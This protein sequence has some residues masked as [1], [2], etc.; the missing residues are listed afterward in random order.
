M[1]APGGASLAAVWLGRRAYRPV[2]ALQQELAA[3]RRRGE[4]RDVLLLLEHE[5]VV[6]LGRGADRA[7][8]LGGEALL[9]ARGLDLV[10]TDRG[11]DVT[12]HAPGQLVGYPIVALEGP[13][14]DVRRWVRDL[15]GTMG[16]V[17][18]ALG[19]EGG[20]VPG[21]V[22][23]W[24]DE[25][26][27]GAFL[28]AERAL[29][30]AKLGAVGVHVSRW[31]T[32]HGFA[33][34]LTTSLELFDLI[35][36]CGIRSHGVTSL[37]ALGVAVPDRVAAA[38]LAAAALAARLGAPSPRLEDLSALPDSALVAALLRPEPGGTPG[39]THDP[40]GRDGG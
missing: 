13:R 18:R 32:T 27:P 10:E 31:V 7:H 15:V 5:P 37:A 36:P 21:L 33:L 30:L 8:L 29:R 39:P 9:L 6:T 26:V 22:G 12:L 40:A 25:A 4:G 3:A 1:T 11:G 23:L 28:G 38:A 17:A 35:V 34:N 20:E 2:L 16:D 14:R 24:V 19:V